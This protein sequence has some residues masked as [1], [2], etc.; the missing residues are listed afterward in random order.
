M[1]LTSNVASIST[2][3]FLVPFL[4]L[5]WIRLVLG[6]PLSWATF[7][8]LVVII[9]GTV[10]QQRAAAGRKERTEGAGRGRDGRGSGSSI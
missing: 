10:M 1:A 8:G 4:A 5:F 3:P 6:E 2:L 9:F 7:A